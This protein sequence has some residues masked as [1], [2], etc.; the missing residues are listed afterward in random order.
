MDAAWGFREA[1]NEARKVKDAQDSFCRKAENGLWDDPEIKNR[2]FPENLK[3]EALVD[4]LRGRVKVNCHTYEAVDIDFLSRVKITSTMVDDSD[5]SIQLTNE[6]K[7]PIAAIH[8]A[9]EAYL[10]PDT[11]KRL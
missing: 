7:F 1:Y 4:V 11:L 8:H 10:V 6:F 5:D 2:D 9:H 3:W